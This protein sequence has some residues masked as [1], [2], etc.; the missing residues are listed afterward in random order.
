MCS[1]FRDPVAE[2]ADLSLERRLMR[3]V[4]GPNSDPAR[5]F[6]RANR[7][8]TTGDWYGEHLGKWLSAA[9]LAAS[10][11]NRPEPAT[12]IADVVAFLRAEQDADGYL[13]TY[14][15][16]NPARFDRETAA[17]VRTWDLWNVAYLLGGLLDAATV[18][19]DANA[20]AAALVGKIVAAFPNERPVLRQGNH[21]GLSAASIVWPFARYIAKD[22]SPAGK[23]LL[24]RLVSELDEEPRNLLR[25]PLEG[26]DASRLGTG[27]AYQLC[28]AYGGLVE[29]ADILGRPEAFESAERFWC[30]VRDRHLTPWGGPWGG[31]AS[32]LEV[33]NDGAFFSPYGL[34]ETCSTMAWMD[35]CWALH[36]RTGRPQ[37]LDE[38][39]RAGLNALLAAR[40]ENGEDWAYFSP[41]NGPRS[42][43]YEW[44]CCKSSGALAL[45]RFAGARVAKS[46]IGLT[47]FVPH[48]AN[49]EVNDALV[50]VRTRYP[51]PGPVTVTVRAAAPTRIRISL[52][53][54][55]EATF[56]A[57][58]RKEQE[59]F[60]ADRN[61]S[62]GETVTGDLAMPAEVV[63]A[64]HRVVHHEREILRMDYVALRAGPLC[65]AFEPLDGFARESCVR[66]PTLF[67]ANR[68]VEV[69]T[70]PTREFLLDAP[71][72]EPIRFVPF[73]EAGRARADRWRNTWLPVVWQ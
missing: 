60:V 52:R 71:G 12:R 2:A 8:E 51:F 47:L 59:W 30:N 68:F 7:S 36:E 70:E 69:A 42:D 54:N 62:D 66:M 21:A 58:W 20:V 63:R 46:G 26:R 61:W 48:S 5:M 33:F 1:A 18:C 39:E 27:K 25:G 44:A 3:F 13:G 37:Y 17:H 38:W 6:A 34:V 22:P 16:R 65:Y 41:A 4:Q 28:L 31:V 56:P 35:L 15:V 50:E 40:H 57:P 10:R 24:A 11:S 43:A 67:D 32:H 45:E 14:H 55:A 29:A 72:H 19:P 9:S 53:A 64:Q 73:A 49:F 23:A